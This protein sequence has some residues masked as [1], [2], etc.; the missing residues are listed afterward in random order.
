MVQ[1]LEARRFLSVSLVDGLLIYEGTG[2]DERVRVMRVDAKGRASDDTT[3][4]LFYQVIEEWTQVQTTYPAEEVTR[5][6]FHMGP[7]NDHVYLG[8]RGP[9][10]GSHARAWRSGGVVV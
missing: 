8:G 1:P 9:T 6:E 2:A 5:M 4:P 10:T 3:Q 7:G